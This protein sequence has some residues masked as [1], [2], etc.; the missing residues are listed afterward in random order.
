MNLQEVVEHIKTVHNG[1]FEGK[2]TQGNIV[3]IACDC[4]SY[5]IIINGSAAEISISARYSKNICAMFEYY[6]SG[7]G[8]DIGTLKFSSELKRFNADNLNIE[9][10]LV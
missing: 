3:S 1:L 5:V 4:T 8:V 9:C 6:I 7:R 10:R 2:D